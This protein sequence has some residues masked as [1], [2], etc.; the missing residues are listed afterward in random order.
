MV[1]FEGSDKLTV[2]FRGP[3]FPVKMG[4]SGTTLRRDLIAQYPVVAM[5]GMEIK[6]TPHVFQT[7]RQE[8]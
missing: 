8:P 1:F 6:F 5:P 4:R 2:G 3:S 7:F